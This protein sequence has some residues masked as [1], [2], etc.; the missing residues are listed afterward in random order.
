MLISFP[1]MANDNLSF[2]IQGEIKSRCDISFPKGIKITLHDQWESQLPFKVNCNHP[3]E[4]SLKSEQGG[5]ILSEGNS[6]KKNLI[7][8][9]N[10]DISMPDLGLTRQLNSADINDNKLINST[11]QIPFSTYGELRISLQQPLIYAGRYE[12]TLSLDIFPQLLVG[13]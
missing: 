7:H 13:Q 10:L 2:A 5:L 6:N 1:I 12:D 9:Y 8:Q 3:F 11:E 4:L